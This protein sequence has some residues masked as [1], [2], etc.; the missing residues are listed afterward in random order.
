MEHSFLS[1][2]TLISPEKKFTA[3]EA[4]TIPFWS[5][6]LCWTSRDRPLD[7]KLK[8]S[9]LYV[10]LFGFLNKIS[11]FKRCFLVS[12]NGHTQSLDLRF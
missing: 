6:L 10:L 1:C 5:P 11:V 8:A 4:E 12:S 3:L 2:W 7:S 9:L